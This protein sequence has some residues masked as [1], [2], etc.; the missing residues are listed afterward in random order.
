M[1]DGPFHDREQRHPP[2]PYTYSTLPDSPAPPYHSSSTP[3]PPSP[4]YYT[5]SSTT[6]PSPPYHSSSTPTPPSPAPAPRST[7][8]SPVPAR[9][10]TSSGPTDA[11]IDALLAANGGRISSRAMRQL[12][13]KVRNR[14]E[15]RQK[16]MSRIPKTKTHDSEGGDLSF[17]ANDEAP[18]AGKKVVSKYEGEDK[19]LTWRASS[20][21]AAARRWGMDVDSPEFRAEYARYRQSDTITTRYDTSP[22]D[23]E[24]SR[25]KEKPDGKVKATHDLGLRHGATHDQAGW[26]MDPTTGNIHTFDEHNHVTGA[27]GKSKTMHHSSPLAGASVAGAGMLTMKDKHITEITDQSG[28]YRP[29]G[30][31]TYQ[32]VKAMASRGLLDRKATTAEVRD[33]EAGTGTMSARVSLTGF[34]S[35]D[36]RQQKGWLEHEEGIDKDQLTLPY[37]AF[38]QTHGNERQARAKKSMQAELLSQVPKIA[39]DEGSKA[40][41][42]ARQG[43]SSL[44][45]S[46]PARDDRHTPDSGTY[47][48]DGDDRH[49]PD[50][51]TYVY[52]G[53]QAT[54]EGTYVYDGDDRHTPDSGTYVYDGDQPTP[55]GAYWEADE[56]GE[57]R[58]SK[59]Y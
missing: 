59:R 2:E 54:P 15:K 33:N 14:D 45:A 36:P 17:A 44:V 5:Y 49:T 51:G 19:G 53:D 58:P 41:R 50:S 39:E 12:E 16:I 8:P 48:Y 10:P 56:S 55:E 6:S 21:R 57:L 35:N 52:D 29:E 22:W 47:V 37:Q 4:A 43:A 30:E 38:L 31:Y 46:R 1:S 20:P 32:A 3:T 26:V 40:L 27:N 7:S 34:A 9:A 25:L 23:R 11:E 18:L 13:T 28:H 42:Q 24:K